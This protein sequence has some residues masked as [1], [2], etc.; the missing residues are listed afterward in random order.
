[1]VERAGVSVYVLHDLGAL[2]LVPEAAGFRVVVSGH[3]HEPRVEERSGAL[4]VNPGSAGPRR[5]SL[6]VAIAR[7]Y[8]ERE[9]PA[10][11]VI[12]LRVGGTV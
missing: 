12:E 5:G 7:L 9:R 8:V 6:P 3:T 10:A 11:Q 1:V 4:Y 2:D